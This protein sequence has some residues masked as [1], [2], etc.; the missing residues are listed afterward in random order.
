MSTYL[1]EE[2]ILFSCD[3]FGSHLAT[4]EVFV[5]NEGEVLRAAKRGRGQAPPVQRLS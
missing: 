1:P 5:T 3:F 2:K 4:N